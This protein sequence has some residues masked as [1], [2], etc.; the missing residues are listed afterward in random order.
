MN[1]K[2]KGTI[3][4]IIFS[5]L[6]TIVICGLVVLNSE[7]MQKRYGYGQDAMATEKMVIE[8]YER[9]PQG[10]DAL[11]ELLCAQGKTRSLRYEASVGL[12]AK[13]GHGSSL[14]FLPLDDEGA[15]AVASEMERLAHW[16]RVTITF[17][18]D[19]AD[20]E[21]IF[22]VDF[23]VRQHVSKVPWGKS[24][25]DI[26]LRCYMDGK[27]EKADVRFSGGK[28]LSERWVIVVNGLV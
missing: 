26:Y 22:A 1:R 3:C 17:L 13:E 8:A 6:L 2:R 21:A 24:Y 19:A 23:T 11:V 16:E 4:M 12:F 7:W 27:P 5:V 14:E 9:D 18:T 28:W 25:V 15:A 20:E 10:F